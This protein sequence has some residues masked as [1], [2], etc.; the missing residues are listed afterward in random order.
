MMGDAAGY[1]APL[2]AHIQIQ[3]RGLPLLSL[4]LSLSFSPPLHV[5]LTLWRGKQKGRSHLVPELL[6]RSVLLLT[7]LNLGHSEAPKRQKINKSWTGLA[8]RKHL[9]KE[10]RQELKRATGIRGVQHFAHN[11]RPGAMEKT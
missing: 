10:R 1:Y 4:P 9:Q 8:T 3:K 11:E 5:C 6:Q 2:Y 7:L